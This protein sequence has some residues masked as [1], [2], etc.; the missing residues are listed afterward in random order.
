MPEATSNHPI[1]A[2]LLA[3]IES[4]AATP[5]PIVK[6]LEAYLLSLVAGGGPT[7]T[8]VVPAADVQAVKACAA[9]HGA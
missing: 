1:L 5:G 7:P 6:A 4:E 2:E 8:P 9:K 3:L